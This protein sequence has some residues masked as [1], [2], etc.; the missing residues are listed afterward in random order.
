M[1]ELRYRRC[2]GFPWHV[3]AASTSGDDLRSKVQPYREWRI[4]SQADTG[5]L[6]WEWDGLGVP[7]QYR[8]FKDEEGNK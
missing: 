4:V 3:V 6:Y 8:D 2:T 1:L 5:L 7:A